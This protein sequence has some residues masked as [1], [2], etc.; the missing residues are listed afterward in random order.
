M[1]PRTLFV[2]LLL[3]LACSRTG[4][5]EPATLHRLNHATAEFRVNG[6]V[7]VHDQISLPYAW[8]YHRRTTGGTA[9]FKISFPMAAVDPDGSYGLY[10]PRLGNAYEIRLNG[11]LLERRGFLDIAGGADFA[12]IPRYFAVPM[13]LLKPSNDMQI[14]I[15]ADTGRRGGLSE[16][17]IGPEAQAA[18]T[19]WKRYHWRVT[20]TVVVA[21]F[22]L[23]VGLI[24]LILWA[25]Q[26]ETIAS[27]RLQR[28]P[29]YLFAGL[30]EIAWSARIGDALLET[31][32]L[33]WPLWGGVPVAAMAI[34]IYCMS[35][36]CVMA[37]DWTH[38]RS[39]VLFSRWI[40]VLACLGGP[41]AYVALGH[42]K[43]LVLTLWYAAVLV[44]F[45]GFSGFFVARS[46]R[47]PQWAPRWIAFAIVLNVVV[48]MRDFYV[49]RIDPSYP[50]NS[51]MRYSSTVFG[52]ALGY[53]V[54]TR[55]RAA[56]TQA[57]DLLAHMTN[58]IAQR[59]LAL[60]QSYVRVEASAR[61]Q[62]RSLER[63]SILRD[64]HDGVG[65]NISSAIRQVQS[66]LARPDQ[67]L[68][69]L[70]E[71]L[72][73]LKLTVDSMHLP[74]GDVVAMLAN[75]RYRLGARIES[76]GVQLQWDVD[77]LPPVERLDIQG[78]RSLQ[79]IV[80]ELCSNVLQHSKADELRISAKAQG[81]G[82]RLLV[83]DN[84]RGF[85][86]QQLGQNGLAGLHERAIA[87]GVQLSVSSH[88]GETIVTLDIER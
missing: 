59:E 74:A 52:V 15:R 26:T 7:T 76:A 55:F 81:D 20:G 49:F 4:A 42:Q 60:E 65:A 10:I 48:G 45:L 25:T 44:S 66:G 73:Q 68:E 11:V 2:L 46:F 34:W 24:S 22:S 80:L 51:W 19:Y 31:P 1:S 32:P 6:V 84:G 63:A 56:T 30:A 50:D 28:D 58:R 8:D 38:N 35:K 43:P 64:M 9:Q 13:Q 54:V 17:Y 75:L 33:A 40:G 62:A 78:M 14:R 21:G 67:I 71:S 37:A 88:P 72:D 23:F 86:A 70:R 3:A 5:N 27:T 18:A 61:E 29:L 39:A 53:F 79:F 36:F 87:I 69:T 47:E 77:F 57:R 41:I 82:I 85:D 16:L 12:Q 83:H